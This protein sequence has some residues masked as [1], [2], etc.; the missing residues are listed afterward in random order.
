[1]AQGQYYFIYDYPASQCALSRLRI[2]EQGMEIASRF[3]LFHGVLELANGFHE[4]QSALQQRLRFEADN[5]SRQL[6]SRPMMN[7]DEHLLAAL[8]HGLPDCSGVAIGLDRLLMIQCEKN[9]IGEVLTF[10]WERI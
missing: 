6:H 5:R 8:E 2:D 1:M 7:I 9:S 4:L 3:E 10:P